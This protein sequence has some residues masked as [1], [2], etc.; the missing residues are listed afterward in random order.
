MLGNNGRNGKVKPKIRIPGIGDKYEQEGRC[1]LVIVGRSHDGK[2]L[3]RKLLDSI[4]EK[5]LFMY[6]RKGLIAPGVILKFPSGRTFQLI[7]KKGM[8]DF[9]NA[10]SFEI[11]EHTQTELEQIAANARL[12]KCSM[13][14]TG[15]CQMSPDTISRS[16]RFMRPKS[17]KPGRVK[18]GYE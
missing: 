8:S 4:S 2:F 3:T 6:F 17:G 9:W 13:P 5:E 11:T 15:L 1:P 7:G 16:G 18:V 10:V 14:I 12:S